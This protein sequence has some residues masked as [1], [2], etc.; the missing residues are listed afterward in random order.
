MV[1]KQPKG[2]VAGHCLSPTWSPSSTLLSRSRRF[3]PGKNN[4]LTTVVVVDDVL[5]VD[6]DSLVIVHI[7]FT[8]RSH[9]TPP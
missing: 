4:L 9:S 3:V 1:P 8:L 2:V 6:P 7:P 5:D